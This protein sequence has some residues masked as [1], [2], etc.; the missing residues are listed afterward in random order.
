MK[1]CVCIILYNKLPSESVTLNCLLDIQYIDDSKVDIFIF[2]NGPYSV[3]NDKVLNNDILHLVEHLNNR[4]LSH[5]YNDFLLKNAEYDRY[6]ILDDDTPIDDEFF[7]GINKYYVSKID[8]QVPVI[9]DSKGEQ[10]YYPLMNKKIY[11]GST[12]EVIY[13]NQDFLTIGSG[14]V[15]YKSLLVKFNVIGENLFDNRFAFYGVDFSLFRRIKWLEKK[16]IQVN[17][18]IPASLKHSLSRVENNFSSWRHL[19]RIHDYALSARYYSGNKLKT[20][21]G[22]IL[23]LSKECVHLRLKNIL[24]FFKTFINGKH[25]RC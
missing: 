14:L 20:F 13:N 18:Q 8:L 12:S 16:N 25:P 24:V 9:F 19:E 7:H 5:I 23:F 2:N 11:Q 21:C 22:V 1:T 4:P 6:I 15:V 10:R 17:I 3:A